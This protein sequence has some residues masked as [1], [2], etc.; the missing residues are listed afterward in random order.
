[1]NVAFRIDET[2][3]VVA[4]FIE[5]L[6][7]RNLDLVCYAHIGQHSSCDPTCVYQNTRPAKPHEYKSLLAELQGR[8]ENTIVV[9]NKLPAFGKTMMVLQNKLKSLT[10]R[11]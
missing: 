11:G 6:S 8:Y 3:E 9:K 4:I 10:N 5:E 1:M 7:T 2:K